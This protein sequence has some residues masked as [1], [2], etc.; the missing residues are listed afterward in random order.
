M[1]FA[2]RS[3][4]GALMYSLYVG[5]GANRAYQGGFYFGWTV[6][7]YGGALKAGSS[8]AAI[9]LAPASVSLADQT[10]YVFV[11]GTDDA[12]YY[13]TYDGW[14]SSWR[15]L[16]IP[17]DPRPP[18]QQVRVGSDPSVGSTGPGKLDVC[19]VGTDSAVWCRSLDAGTW[20]AWAY[21]SF[22]VGGA[23]GAPAVSNGTVFVRDAMADQVHARSL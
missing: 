7:P 13:L 17:L 1:A 11:R 9:S 2:R 22:P 20:G 3:S 5:Y 10:T 8:P 12:L 14:W 21:K 4:D 23:G 6:G 18:F 15:S 16:G 19:V